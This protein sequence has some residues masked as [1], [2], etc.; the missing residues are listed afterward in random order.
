MNNIPRWFKV[1]SIIII[2]LSV[3]I[4]IM[5]SAITIVPGREKDVL[6]EFV[7]IH[8]ILLIILIASFIIMLTR[9]KV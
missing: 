9:R 3:A 2:A 6:M 1:E 8:G 7:V 4:F 5:Q